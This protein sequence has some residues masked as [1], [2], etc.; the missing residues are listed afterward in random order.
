MLNKL[1]IVDTNQTSSLPSLVSEDRFLLFL[2]I[3]V[4]LGNYLWL[5]THRCCN[6]TS[7]KDSPATSNQQRPTAWNFGC[8]RFL[9]VFSLLLPCLC[10]SIV[11]FFFWSSLLVYM[12]CSK[13]VRDFQFDA[14]HSIW[15]LFSKK[16]FLSPL[17]EV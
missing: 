12:L 11:G 3:Q 7:H 13:S 10:C 2:P 6:Y 5:P 17:Y 8:F 14:T 4:L 1:L 16:P 15:K 9:T